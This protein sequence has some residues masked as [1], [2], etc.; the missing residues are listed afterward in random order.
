MLKR[1]FII[2]IVFY[3]YSAPTIAS[4]GWTK[5]RYEMVRIREAILLYESDYGE[6]LRPT[7]NPDWMEVLIELNYFPLSR[8]DDGL[9]AG[10][11]LLPL[12]PYG[13]PYHVYWHSES[14]LIVACLGPN[15]KDDDGNGDDWVLGNGPNIGYWYK[16][17]WP[18]SIAITFVGLLLIGLS[19]PLRPL[20]G[21]GGWAAVSV[22]VGGLGMVSSSVADYDDL[23][24]TNGPSRMF[25][26][27][28]IWS[29]V[30]GILSLLWWIAS[31]VRRIRRWNSQH[32]NGHCACGYNLAFSKSERCPECGI[33]HR[34][35]RTPL[36]AKS[37]ALD[38]AE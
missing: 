24:G 2:L 25:L 31:L 15:R 19:I 9:I 37:S 13:S 20:R 5:T 38:K 1:V 28:F 18:L 34:S 23:I 27:I 35:L 22:C 26:R 6:K 4:G 33:R 12:D 14:E 16:S 30:I 36:D 7:R 17:D 29:L 32:R 3:V 10:S 11:P 21:R 8:A